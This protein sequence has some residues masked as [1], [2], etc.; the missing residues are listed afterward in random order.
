MDVRFHCEKRLR[1]SGKKSKHGVLETCPTVLQVLRLNPEHGLVIPRFDDLRKMRLQVPGLNVGKR[2]EF[3]QQRAAMHR[4]LLLET[5]V[6]SGILPPVSI[7]VLN[8][9]DRLKLRLDALAAHSRKPL[10]DWAAEQLGHL[11]AGAGEILAATYSTE[12]MAAFGSID[13]ASFGA[14]ERVLPSAVE[15]LSAGA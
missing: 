9:D 3:F 2:D 12:W 1:R 11:A 8:L 6:I 13:D 10:P 4:T 15:P 5:P 7:L 14:P